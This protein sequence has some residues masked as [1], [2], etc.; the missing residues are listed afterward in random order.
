MLIPTSKEAEHLQCEV[1]EFLWWCAELKGHYED[2]TYDK[3][4]TALRQLGVKVKVYRPND[5]AHERWTITIKAEILD[6][7][8]GLAPEIFSDEDSP[9]NQ[10]TR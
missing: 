4:R 3:K 10:S 8:T 6:K 9:V 2:A 1:D 5:P 7:L